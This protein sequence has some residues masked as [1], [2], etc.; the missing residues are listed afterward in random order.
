MTGAYPED[1]YSLKLKSNLDS[2][3]L[4]CADAIS[5]RGNFVHLLHSQSIMFN[6]Y[7]DDFFSPFLCVMEIYASILQPIWFV[8]DKRLEK[9]QKTNWNGNADERVSKML[10]R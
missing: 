8:R 3:A 4:F 7:A 5:I 10:M 1:V 2:I 9:S 6:K